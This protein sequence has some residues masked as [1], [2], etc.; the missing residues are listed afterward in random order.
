MMVR[1][2][3]RDAV[4]KS[5]CTCGSLPGIYRGLAPSSVIKHFFFPQDTV[6]RG[7]GSNVDPFICKGWNNLAWRHACVFCRIAGI[8]D[9]PSGFLWNLI[10]WFRMDCSRTSI[11]IGLCLTFPLLPTI[12]GS[13][14]DPKLLAGFLTG[15][16]G[17]HCFFDQLYGI[18]AV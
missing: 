13:L 17:F 8:D 16:T 6:K 4:A 15:S 18:L 2:F 12:I 9:L 10:G 3:S 14:C 11:F 1:L 7:L 5:P